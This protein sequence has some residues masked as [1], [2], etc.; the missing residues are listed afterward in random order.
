VDSSRIPV[1]LGLGSVKGHSTGILSVAIH[2]SGEFLASSDK[3]G[4][5]KLWKLSSGELLATLAGFSP[6]AFSADGKILVSGGNNG[7]IQI[8]QQVQTVEDLPLVGEWWEI[9]GV[10]PHT[11]AKQVKLAYLKLARL[12]HPDVNTSA[13]AKA[14]MQAIN[15]PYQNFQKLL[16]TRSSS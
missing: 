11:P 5:I 2:P 3:D 9:L 15:Q 8:W 6:L 13:S 14:A 16:R 4:V 7:T 1:P 12:Y 10:E